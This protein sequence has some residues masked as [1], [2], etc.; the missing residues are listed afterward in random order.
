MKT[1]IGSKQQLLMVSFAGQFL[2]PKLS[3][4]KNCRKTTEGKTHLW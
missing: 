4:G 3:K 2:F 1:V